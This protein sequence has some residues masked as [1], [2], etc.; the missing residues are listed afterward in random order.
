MIINSISSGTFLLL[1]FLLFIKSFHENRF[2][3]RWL[4]ISF[5]SIGLTLLDVPLSLSDFY[6][7]YPD[8]QEIIGLFIFVLTPCIYLATSY[9]VSPNRTFTIKDLLH[10]FVLPS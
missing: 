6:K 3:N 2:A 9:F 10:F 5:I 4:G 8:F 1:S 7:Q